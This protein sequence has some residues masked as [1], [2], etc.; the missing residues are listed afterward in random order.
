M[1]V[2]FFY[3]LVLFFFGDVSVLIIIN[4][5]VARSAFVCH[6]SYC[7]QVQTDALSFLQQDVAEYR[8][9]RA[10]G[11]MCFLCFFAEK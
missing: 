6:A 5:Q 3:F 10:S 11:F 1:Y 8:W 7:M 2:F 9:C 4:T